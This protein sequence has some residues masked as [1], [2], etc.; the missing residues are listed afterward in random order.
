MNDRTKAAYRHLLYVAMLDIRNY[1][2]S[3]SRESQ[4]PFEWRRQ[5]QRSRVAGA[6]A[7][8]LH[9]LAQISSAEFVSFDEQQFWKEHAGLCRRLPGE[10]IERYR[11]FFD[12]FVAGKASIC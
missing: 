8:W 4:N 10:G 5:Y 7:D 3:R 6:I 2:Q 1:C 12:E 11:K 9:N